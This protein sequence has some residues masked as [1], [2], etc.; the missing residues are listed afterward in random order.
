[1]YG[2][3]VQPKTKAHAYRG[4]ASA[5]CTSGLPSRL[6]SLYTRWA[7]GALLAA[8][9]ALAGCGGGTGI[10]NQT[11]SGSSQTLAPQLAVTPAA[12][13]FGDVTAGTTGSQNVSLSN[14]GTGTLTVSEVS[15]SGA[16]FALS[17]LTLPLSLT[18]G[19]SATFAVHFSPTSAGNATGS[20][21]IFSNAPNSLLTVSMTGTAVTQTVSASPASLSF[22]NVLVTTSSSLPVVV[23]N[24]GTANVVISQA[25][26]AGTGFG[27][28]GPPLP[29]TLAVAQSVSFSVTFAPTVGGNVTGSLTIVSNALN[30]PIAVSLVG[31]A[32]TQGLSVSPSGLSFGD[33]TLGSTSTLPVVV[34]NIG[35]G[36][37]TI[38]QA[39]ASGTGFSVSGPT[40]PFALGAGA[41]ASFSVEFDPT[42]AASATGSLSI[43]SNATNS[44][45]VVSIS[46]TGVNDQTVSLSW[47]ASTSSGVTGYNIFRATVSGGPYTQLNSAQ[48]T[49]TTYT[50]TTVE[51]GTTYYY[52]A[53]AVNAEGVQSADSNQATAVV[54]SQ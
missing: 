32:V 40:L 54:P 11:E 49:G 50:D 16:G 33:I 3:G 46:G 19:Q 31:T 41:T 37:V 44:P 5:L 18:Q 23:A 34:S 12:V 27:I 15:E 2:R 39:T 21:S 7:A 29:F 25:T 30:S 28:S 38:S 1:M 52:V 4:V 13:A 20:L 43:T 36:G 22:G 51:V 17:A 48:V 47:T 45:T 10:T 14:V 24:T 53:T 42:A 26:V 9:A 8:I 6:R 35:T